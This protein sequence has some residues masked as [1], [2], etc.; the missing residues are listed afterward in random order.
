MKALIEIRLYQ[1]STELLIQKLPFQRL[2]MKMAQDFKRN[3][4]F[5]ADLIAALQE[6]S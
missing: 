5:Q 2:I 1:T 6:A 3:V 4:N